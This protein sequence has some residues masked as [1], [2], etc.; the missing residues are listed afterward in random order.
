MASTTKSNLQQYNDFGIQDDCI[1]GHQMCPTTMTNKC[2][3]GVYQ[4]ASCK[5]VC[6]HNNRWFGS[7]HYDNTPK[8]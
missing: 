1:Q 8:G 6:Q 7:I 3:C 2:H 5:W 4:Q